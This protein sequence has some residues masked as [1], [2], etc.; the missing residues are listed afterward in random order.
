MAVPTKCAVNDQ[1]QLTLSTA[2]LGDRVGLG[3]F[4]VCADEDGRLGG[5][6]IRT[7]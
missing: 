5:A 7:M 1:L 4:K 3:T 2:R 6:A